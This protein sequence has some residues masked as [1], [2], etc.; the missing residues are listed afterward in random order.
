MNKCARDFFKQLLMHTCGVKERC[1]ELSKIKTNANAFYEINF[2]IIYYTLYFLLYLE[3]SAAIL[4]S[5]PSHWYSLR[6]V[7]T[8]STDASIAK[9]Y[10]YDCFGY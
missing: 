10:R 7:T 4:W 3:S 8:C 5:H 6:I 9:K 2:N 1:E